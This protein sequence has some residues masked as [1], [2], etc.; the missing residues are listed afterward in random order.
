MDLHA[1]AL[2]GKLQGLSKDIQNFY[3]TSTSALFVVLINLWTLVM[4]P[5]TPP[6]GKFTTIVGRENTPTFESP[7]FFC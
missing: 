6:T 1:P 7:F 4:H 5:R 3:N 2:T